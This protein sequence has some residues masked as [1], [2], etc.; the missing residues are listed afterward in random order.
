MID[1]GG[2]W[3]STPGWAGRDGSLRSPPGL[4]VRSEKRELLRLRINPRGE[5][6]SPERPV[7][8]Q[9]LRAECAAQRATPCFPLSDP[10]SPAAQAAVN[11]TPVPTGGR[12]TDRR[13]VRPARCSPPGAISERDPGAGSGPPA[14]RASSDRVGEGTSVPLPPRRPTQ[15]GPARD[16]RRLGCPGPGWWQ[17]RRLRP[18]PGA[19]P[20]LAGM[21]RRRCGRPAGR[22][23]VRR[24][25][26]GR[27]GRRCGP[28]RVPGRA[29]R[30]GQP[31]RPCGGRAVRAAAAS[32]GASARG[33]RPVSHR[34]PGVSESDSGPAQRMRVVH[35]SS[36]VEPAPL[37][38]SAGARDT[39]DRSSATGCPWSRRCR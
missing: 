10:R 1:P 2:R 25:G 37:P 21:S 15:V 6:V 3:C 36:Q 32:A 22:A 39:A 16:R 9:P 5:E 17:G 24:V 19:A 13:R 26:A 34:S 7:P 38:S 28:T 30:P 27:V 8:T 11:R 31:R 12:V 29:A 33:S 23:V 18:H 14:R 20:A 35:T 4:S